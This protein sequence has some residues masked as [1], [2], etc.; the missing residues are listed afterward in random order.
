MHF[1][2]KYIARCA[3]L[4]LVFGQ[5][6]WPILQDF[7]A[8]L[9]IRSNKLLWHGE[10]FLYSTELL[11]A[12][13]GFFFLFFFFLIINPWKRSAHL[14]S[15]KFISSDLWGSLVEILLFCIEFREEFLRNYI[16]R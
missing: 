15:C 8:S 9:R 13:A 11:R 12:A 6:K 1:T 3:N 2:E 7:L 5:R 14:E 10:H 4:N 16:P